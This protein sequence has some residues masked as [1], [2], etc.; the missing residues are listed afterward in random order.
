MPRHIDASSTSDADSEMHKALWLNLKCQH[1]FICLQGMFTNIFILYYVFGSLIFGERLRSGTLQ[2]APE[3]PDHV[4]SAPISLVNRESRRGSGGADGAVAR[5]ERASK[6]VEP[7]SQNSLE[8]IGSGQSGLKG[9]WPRASLISAKIAANGRPPFSPPNVSKPPSL[10]SIREL[11]SSSLCPSGSLWEPPTIVDPLTGLSKAGASGSKAPK[12]QGMRET[13]GVT[14]IF[15]P[16]K[17]D[18]WNRLG[19]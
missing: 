7:I 19:G 5:T 2:V 4:K 15:F 1:Q 9:L 16:K 12:T 8:I 14:P 18:L 10:G 3:L 6:R 11:P 13:L 17:G